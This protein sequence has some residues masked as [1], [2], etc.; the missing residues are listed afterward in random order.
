[1]NYSI[2]RYILCRVLEFQALFL[3]LPCIV[4]VCYGEKQ[5]W[6][7]L[8]VAAGCLLI[9]GLG[10]LKKPRST[11]FYAREGFV[12][13]SLSWIMMSITGALPFYFTGEFPTYTDALFETIS[14]FTT[15]GASIL[16]DVEALSRCTMFWRC[17]TH[18]IGGMGVLVLILAVLPLAGGYNM[19]LMRAESPGPTVGK[20][21]PRVRHT[22]RILYE[23][24]VLMTMV[25]IITLLIA[26]MTLY[27]S[28]TLSFGTAGTGGFGLLNTGAAEYSAAVQIILTVF[29]ILFGINFNVYFLIR[30]RKVKDA[31]KHEE[32]RYYLGVIAVAIILIT[33]NV[34]DYFES[35]AEA[36]RH[37]AFQ[38]ASI[39]T[40]TGFSTT[41]F[42]K[43][44]EFSKFI[45]LVLMFVGA[46]AGST[47]G[48]I[49]VS[50]VMT[51]AKLA[52]NEFSYLIHPKRVRQIY[53]EKRVVNKETLR[54]ISVFFIAYTFIY[55]ISVL[56]ISLDNLDFTT[57]FTAVAATLNNIGPGLGMVGP[58][59]N[60]SV[61]S[62]PAKYVLMFDMLAGR[63]ELFPMLLLFT[64]ST[65]KRN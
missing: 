46:C 55:A 49:K 62:T 17:F 23:M 3:L 40:T 4:A 5:G 39:I 31:I 33:V 42:N 36:V 34:K 56:L 32:M 10:K 45:L 35:I 25:E 57:N 52:K 27:D 13:V 7:Y 20:L 65:W 41:D 6:F 38:V 29:M 16:S 18:W 1:M 44:P 2:I 64:P 22:A 48:G 63:L 60:F 12:T 21:V 53:L 9:G 8:L 43:W 14:G 54:S 37:V 24:Y 58:A 28:L 47:G 61:Y 19:Y 11:V 59:S 30:E 26:G 51:M 50:R 15:T